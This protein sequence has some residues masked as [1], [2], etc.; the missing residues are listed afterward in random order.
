MRT[1]AELFDIHI[2]RGQE[3]EGL[4][5]LADALASYRKALKIDPDGHM[6]HLCVADVLLAT[7]R[8]DDALATFETALALSPANPA[9]HFNRGNVLR[10]LSRFEEAVIAYGHAVRLRPDFPIAHHNLACALLQLGDLPAGF[11]EYEW[12]K[13]CPTFDDPRYKMD[14]A[15]SG[16]DLTGKK[17]LVYAELFQG[18]TIQFSRFAAAVERLGAQ[19]VFA[20]PPLMHGLLSTLSATIELVPEDA[21]PDFDYHVP[22]LS[23]PHLLNARIDTVALDVPYLHPD[24]TRLAHWRARIGGEGFKIGVVWQGSTLPYALPLQRSFP[25]A[26]LRGIAAIPGV[27]LISLQKVNGLDQLADLPDGMT[28]ED[29]GETFD[30]GPQMFVD[31]AAAMASCDLVITPDTSAA[32]LAGAL[33]VR[34]WLALPHLADWRWLTDQTDSPWY[35]TMRLFRQSV[36][37]D[38]SGVFSD[39]EDALRNDLR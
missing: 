33:G 21:T 26:S 29:L 34:T 35:P 2:Q 7:G 13:K 11:R 27:R 39:M 38:W 5:R 36:R 1:K 19:V 10:M 8:L 9:T 4:G 28:V 18:D 6:A 32:H 3:L 25:L 12:R 37:G 20:A 24:P 15:W 14:R 17:L 23:L 16:E 22:L 30:P 31:T